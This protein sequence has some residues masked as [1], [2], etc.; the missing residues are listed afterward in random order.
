MRPAPQGGRVREAEHG[1]LAGGMSLGREAGGHRPRAQAAWWGRV[2][3]ALVQREE[4]LPMAVGWGH[5]GGLWCWLSCPRLS[6][7]GPSLGMGSLLS[8]GSGLGT[9]RTAPWEAGRRL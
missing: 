8:G 3:R 5:Q 9:G 2:W 6:Q 1:V 4:C 7:G